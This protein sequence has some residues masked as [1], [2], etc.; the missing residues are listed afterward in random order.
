MAYD[1]SR[2]KT[3]TNRKLI[4]MHTWIFIGGIMVIYNQCLSPLKLWVRIPLMRW[5]NI[6]W[7]SWTWFSSGSP[8]SSTNKTDRHDLTEILL[9]VALNTLTLTLES[10]Y[11]E[12]GKGQKPSFDCIILPGIVWYLWGIT[13]VDCLCLSGGLI[14]TFIWHCGWF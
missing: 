4:V 3:V 10:L 2:D 7:W 12:C 11:L 5:Y 8:V 14:S 13:I 9:K 6:M 1:W